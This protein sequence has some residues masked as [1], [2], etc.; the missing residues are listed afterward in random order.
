MKFTNKIYD[1]L[2]WIA[3]I[4]LPAIATF[5]FTLA[6]IWGL[7]FVEEIL[8]TLTAIDAFIGILLG[9]SSKSYNKTKDGTLAITNIDEEGVTGQ[10]KIDVPTEELINRSEIT[11][12]I[13]SQE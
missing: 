4:V 10:L 3:Q 1:A 9:I 5:Y 13:D 6:S 12:K 7:P 11:L 2:K 8:G